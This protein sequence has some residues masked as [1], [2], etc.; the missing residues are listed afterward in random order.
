VQDTYIGKSLDVYG[1]W[2][3]GEVELFSQ[4]V[5]KGW[6]VVDVGANIGSFTVPFSK[7]VGPLG[8]VVAFEPQ[9][10]LFQLLTANVALNEITNTVVHNMA[11][12]KD[13]GTLQVPKI[14]YTIPAN[15]GALSLNSG[16]PYLENARQE[17][18]PLTTL[19]NLRRSMPE[20]PHFVK[21]D[22]EGMES[23]VLDGASRLL[24]E[25]APIFYIEN[26]CIKDSEALITRM[27]SFNYTMHW[28]VKSY[29]NSENYFKNPD[30]DIFPRTLLSINMLCLPAN[31]RFSPREADFPLIRHAEKKWYLHDYDFDINSGEFGEGQETFHF[32]QNGNLTHCVR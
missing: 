29:L 24:G 3:E 8:T 32:R 26:N 7:L 5:Q 20:C 22:V 4:I 15:F 13:T 27:A 28:D 10:I 12:G 17:Q 21:V 11:V 25:C 18:V 2:S 19:D 9:R 23:A 30:W 31:T 16:E 6:N 1:E 14:N